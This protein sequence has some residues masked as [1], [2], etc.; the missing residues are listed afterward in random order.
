MIEG[1]LKTRG[2]NEKAQ[3]IE[4]SSMRAEAGELKQESSTESTQR[5][6]RRAL[7]RASI[8]L[9]EDESE[10]CPVGACLNR[11]GKGKPG[12]SKKG[13]KNARKE[14]YDL[15]VNIDMQEWSLTRE[16]VVIY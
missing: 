12:A 3:Y 4:S 6:L 2:L 1:E 14:S 8:H 16:Q 10:P 11:G 13:K 9:E 5:A 15:I 7:K